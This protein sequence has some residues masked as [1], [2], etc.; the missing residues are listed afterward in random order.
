MRD[1]RKDIQSGELHDVTPV[2]RNEREFDTVIADLVV[3]SNRLWEMKIMAGPFRE[4]H[5]EY[6]SI[7]SIFR[8]WRHSVAE[9]LKVE[10]QLD[11]A[12][13]DFRSKRWVPEQEVDGTAVSWKVERYDCTCRAVLDGNTKCLMFDISI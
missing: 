3:F 12:Y 9:L 8:F 7:V 6:T 2:L 1:L 5:N 4:G 11:S 10:L 13:V